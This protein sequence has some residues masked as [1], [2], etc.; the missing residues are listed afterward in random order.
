MKQNNLDPIFKKYLSEKDKL[1]IKELIAGPQDHSKGG[2]T[3]QVCFL[4]TLPE[5]H[6]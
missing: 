4:H 1:F 3:Q 5:W 2:A 6:F